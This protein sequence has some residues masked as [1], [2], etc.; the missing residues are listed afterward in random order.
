MRPQTLA[1]WLA[2]AVPFAVYVATASG[3]AYWLDSGEFVAASVQLGIPHPPGHPLS[4]L[5]GALLALLP[6]GS[7]S[8]RVAVGQALAG[9]LASTLHCRASVAALR[10]MDLPLKWLWSLGVFAAWS[11]ALCYGIWF[12]AVRPEVYALQTL[13]VAVIFERLA[14]LASQPLGADLDARAMLGAALALGLALTNHHLVALL[15]VPA[16]LPA[17]FQ[18]W[19]ARRRRTLAAALGLGAL[20][21]ANYLYLP[22][23][24]AANPAINLGNPVDFERFLWVV[25]AQVYAHDMGSAESQPLF[26][27]GL[28]VLLLLLESF[29]AL[30]L[31]LALLGLYG[32]FRLRDTRRVALLCS[33]VFGVDVYARAWLGPV[34]SN[35]DI[36][37][38]LAPGL[39]VIGTLAAAA[40]AMVV[41]MLNRQYPSAA[42]L[43]GR[44]APLL[45]IC[46][47]AWL[48]QTQTRSSLRHFEATDAFDETRLR[49]L[50]ARAVIVASMPQTVF[51][52]WEGVAVEGARPDLVTIPLPFLRYP[53]SSDALVRRHPDVSNLVGSFLANHDHIQAAA[54][55]QLAA[56]RPVFVELDARLSPGLYPLLRPRGLLTQ[57]AQQPQ[58]VS[59]EEARHEL[60]R[61]YG[62]LYGLLGRDAGE[63]ETARQL[64][65]THYMNALQL[66]GLGM[67]E[68]A[69]DEAARALAVQPLD[70]H[71][72]ALVQALSQPEPL[73]AQLFLEF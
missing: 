10:G 19:R 18:A 45:P 59:P 26:E 41:D 51:R 20:G 16:F 66:D 12:Q 31:S 56:S 47:L 14:T 13:C 55:T 4:A 30:P 25:S 11:S 71:T 36:L 37:G 52:A 43:L 64:L 61:V 33:L 9:G 17:L 15:L 40:L 70:K 38:Y 49:Y 42:A 54:L 62:N 7:L 22:L 50:P 60:A 58:H 39:L 68:L 29:H 3:Y 35:P 23:R 8:F 28:D 65:W 73:S 21:L 63:I 6:V 69:R 1:L 44:C 24:A 32:L 27:R 5:F 67:R 46:A 72:Q 34:R 57:L 53:G 48:P 2:G